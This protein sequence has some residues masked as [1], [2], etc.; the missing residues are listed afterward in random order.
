MGSSKGLQKMMDN[1]NKSIEG[2]NIVKLGNADMDVERISSGSLEVDWVLGGGWAKG[3][4]HEIYGGE[5][6]GK[7]TLCLHTIAEVQKTGGTAAFVDMEHALDPEWAKVIGV[8]TDNLVFLQPDYGE[9][10]LEVV[11]QM[12]HSGEVDLIIVD[13][14]AALIP[15]SE[16]KGEM[17]DQAVGK[18]AK[19]MAQACRK[20]P[21]S[22][23]KTETT[24]IFINQ[25]REKIGV[26]FGSPVTTPGGNALKF[27][28]SQRLEVRRTAGKKET[29]GTKLSNPMKIK[30]VKNKVSAPFKES[31][32]RITYGIG[33]DS[34]WETLQVAVEAEI[35]K[36]AGSFFSFRD[37]KIAQGE[38]NTL[39]MLRDNPELFEEIVFLVKKSM[40]EEK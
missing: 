29:D 27:T 23:K 25:T 20:L 40:A 1:L 39:D 11:D 22:A 9:Q 5:S 3:R 21:Q 18:Q 31:E 15:E 7:T 30:C 24:V 10:A 17:G 2:V 38:K 19:M 28:V 12:C 33:I 8:D 37:T 26:M 13:S 4:I 36:K 14:V 16:L 34:Y 6:S 32:T 35:V